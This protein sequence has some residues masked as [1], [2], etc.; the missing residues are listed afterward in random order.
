MDI[1]QFFLDYTTRKAKKSGS[2]G[3]EWNTSA[4]GLF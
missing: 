4:T 2:T 3:I 1:F